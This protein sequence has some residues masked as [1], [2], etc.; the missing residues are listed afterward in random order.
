MTLVDPL[1]LAES[2]LFPRQQVVRLA[3]ALADTHA[4]DLSQRALGL[5]LQVDTE[6]PLTLLVRDA[7][8]QASEI[9]TAS[10]VFTPGR[11]AA[12]LA[13]AAERRIAVG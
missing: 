8:R 7:R 13:E 3:P 10:V 5:A 6:A 4:T 11:P 1:A 12:V 9:D 2:V